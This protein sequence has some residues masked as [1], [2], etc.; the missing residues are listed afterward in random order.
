MRALNSV[1]AATV[2]VCQ[3]PGSRQVLMSILELKF[4]M[5]ARSGT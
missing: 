4:P 2:V 3:D 1:S 5:I